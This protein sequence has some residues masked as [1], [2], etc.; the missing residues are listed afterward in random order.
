MSNN[1][2]VKKPQ[3]LKVS[4]D[5]DFGKMA[6]G[7]IWN[8]L[9]NAYGMWCEVKPVIVFPGD[10]IELVEVKFFATDE[11]AMEIEQF[12]RS[13]YQFQEEE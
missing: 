5:P 6:T 7:E 10:P 11:K 2:Q 4:V 13:G 3:R 9:K 8:T 1:R 12:L